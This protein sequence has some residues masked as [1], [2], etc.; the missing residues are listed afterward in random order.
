MKDNS[1]RIALIE[2]LNIL[3]SRY[4][5]LEIEWAIPYLLARLNEEEE[6]SSSYLVLTPLYFQRRYFGSNKSRQRGFSLPVQENQIIYKYMQDYLARHQSGDCHELNQSGAHPLFVKKFLTDNRLKRIVLLPLYLEGFLLGAVQIHCNNSTEFEISE[7]RSEICRIFTTLTSRALASSY[8]DSQFFSNITENLKQVFFMFSP[9]FSKLHFVSS[10]FENIF[11]VSESSLYSQPLK[12]L[13]KIE[14]GGQEEI[15]SYLD[16]SDGSEPASFDIQVVQ[17]DKEMKWVKLRFF[18]VRDESGF[19]FRISALAEDITE[20]KLSEMNM[21]QAQAY[22]FEIGARIQKALLLGSP[23]NLLKGLSLTASSIPS[24]MIDGDFYDF[25]SF[26]D[27]SLDLVVG[28]VMGKGVAAALM[29]AA[30]KT[31]FIRSR[32][33]LSLLEDLRPG[34]NDVL[35]RV[36][37]YLVRQMIELNNFLTLAYLRLDI[38]MH[39]LEFVDCGH[40]SIMLLKGGTD[41]SWRL[42]GGNMPLGFLENQ[43]YRKYKI[44]IEKGDLL[45][46]YSDGITEAENSE[47]ELFGETRLEYLLR[48]MR[49]L[50]TDEIVKKVQNITFNY[51]AAGFSDDVTCVA[52]R[53]DELPGKPPYQEKQFSLENDYLT[54][55]RDYFTGVIDKFGASNTALLE[56]KEGIIL[57]VNEA[58]ANI[59][60]HGIEKMTNDEKSTI[61]LNVGYFMDWMS[62]RI[63]Y[64]GLDYDWMSAELPDVE[65]YQIGGYGLYIIN[66]IMES[67]HFT[68]NMNG[69]CCLTLSASF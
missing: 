66:T 64:N 41:D 42:K 20:I 4:E 53:I 67:V 12:F 1:S 35:S 51:S 58:M 49:N 47:G 37:H 5:A 55:I 57:A 45:F 29:G 39:S 38:K 50:T 21:L 63:Y 62:I 68:R 7:C 19:I 44:P 25:F 2:D 9:D 3:F 36:D 33:D 6:I 13:E 60:R 18:P 16:D 31:S 8:T 54:E 24:K 46:L 59:A 10:G 27:I 17:E 11:H 30:A 23:E 40:T 43:D 32:L 52:L 15:Q 48:T 26:D 28:D 34:I 14:H 69:R 22:E 61:L 65:T 56:K